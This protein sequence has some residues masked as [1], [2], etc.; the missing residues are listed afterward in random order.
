MRLVLHQQSYAAQQGFEKGMV[1]HHMRSME[2]WLPPWA[3]NQSVKDTL[4]S[5]RTSRMPP[6]GSNSA[7]TTG[8]VPS[9]SEF[10]TC[11]NVQRT[12]EC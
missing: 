5:A 10:C 3:L 1:A 8:D 7:L 9:A 4:S 12:D 6:S 11:R 2:P